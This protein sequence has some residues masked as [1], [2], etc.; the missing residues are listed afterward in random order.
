MT[1]PPKRKI[2]GLFDIIDAQAKG[3]DWE[4]EAI[5]EDF[6][7]GL[8][9]G[10][11][12]EARRWAWLGYRYEMLEAVKVRLKRKRGPPTKDAYLTLDA[13]RARYLWAFA[14]TLTKGKGGKISSR[15]LIQLAVEVAK[16]TANPELKRLFLVA[17]NVEYSVSRGKK[18]MDID[19]QWCSKVCEQLMKDY[20]Q[21]T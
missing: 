18:I 16:S 6:I 1:D 7:P 12:D 19:A 10:A 5:S 21:T 8:G 14:D 20:P 4:L 3:E 9:V 11:T 13:K 17:D 15:A 2:R